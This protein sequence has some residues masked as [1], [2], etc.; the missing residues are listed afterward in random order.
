MINFIFIFFSFIKYSYESSGQQD[1]PSEPTINSNSSSYSI[2]SQQQN[3]DW[4]YINPC[5]T[6]YQDT[7]IDHS[8]PS[9][10]NKKK[11]RIHSAHD[12]KLVSNSNSKKILVNVI[13]DKPLSTKSKK[14]KKTTKK[15]IY[16]SSNTIIGSRTMEDLF[17]V[18]NKQGSMAERVLIIDRYDSD[19]N[20]NKQ[21]QPTT[22]TSTLN[23][24]YLTTTY[25]GN[26][27]SYFPF[28]YY[29]Y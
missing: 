26:A 17:Q 22:Y 1:K 5:A 25:V 4:Y 19:N 16:S 3:I 29:Q 13:N 24:I 23:N 11:L 28:M 12:K 9:S 2:N 14:H 8:R 10:K 27:N 6:Y 18:I 15:R 21:S 20:Q 7:N